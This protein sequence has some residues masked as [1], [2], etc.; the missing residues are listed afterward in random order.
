MLDDDWLTLQIAFFVGCSDMASRSGK[1]S[2]TIGEKVREESA[3]E[4]DI[5]QLTDFDWDELYFLGHT[6]LVK[7]F[8]PYSL[9]LSDYE[10]RQLVLAGIDEGEY[11]LVFRYSDEICHS[12]TPLVFLRRFL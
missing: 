1:I 10:C 11:L 3:T 4:I 9:G 6:S 5:A 12:K 7:K 8:A 2:Q